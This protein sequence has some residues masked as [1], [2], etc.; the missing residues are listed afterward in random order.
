MPTKKN[1]TPPA[2]A[3]G[4]TAEELI[5]VSTE[6]AVEWLEN[7]A[8]SNTRLADQMANNVVN[9]M[10]LAAVCDIK[11]QM[12]Y[13]YIRSGRLPS[14]TNNTEKLVIPLEA[15]VEFV[16]NRLEKEAQKKQKLQRELA[17]TGNNNS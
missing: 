5:E 10:V 2:E 8:E 11:P 6:E 17:G 7:E 12:V 13:N 9:P 4:I 3:E 1:N 16:R 14:H 15:A